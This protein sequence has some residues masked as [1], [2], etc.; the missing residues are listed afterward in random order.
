MLAATPEATDVPAMMQTSHAPAEV[1]GAVRPGGLRARLLGIYRRLPV[2][3]RAPA[4]RLYWRL[5]LR[6]ARVPRLAPTAATAWPVVEAGE[7]AGAGVAVRVF[8]YFSGQ[9]GLG[10]SARL[11]THALR[12][13]SV[14]V[15]VHDLDLGLP[16]ATHPF[17]LQG[18]LE[19]ATRVIDLVVV[20]PDYLARALPL[21]PAGAERGVARIACWFWELE[22]VPAS[23]HWALAH[24]EGLLVA[25]RFV[26]D[27]VR[28]VASI[29]VA[30]VPLPVV[31]R[32]ASTLTR[33]EFGVPADA[34]LFLSSFDFHSS[35]RRKNP[36]AV[37][38]AFRLA[39]PSGKEPVALLIKSS[40]GDQYPERLL[41]LLELAACD[42]R[43]IIRDGVI[44]PAHVR[45]LQ[46]WSD[47]F[48]SLHR[49][50]GF[51]LGLAE[52]MAL[53]KPVIA[54]GWSGNLEFM[55]EATAWLVGHW[56]VDVAP[57][58]Y[59]DA[60]GARWAEPDVEHAAR[61]MREVA[62]DRAATARTAAAGAARVARQL[63]AGHIGR[64]LHRELV[65]IAA[66]AAAQ[67][68]REP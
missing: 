23:W 24:F 37:I 31:A 11:Y 12:V 9:F 16:H 22:R 52:C 32:P 58:E 6:R 25:S 13:A 28:H 57:G 30:V 50:E 61:L 3:L 46:Q 64:M 33:G 53:G 45:A 67:P 21:L 17:P 8:G 59:A 1:D 10:E 34:F 15:E 18:A 19:G 14:P 4:S 29:P 26:A 51:G 35:I 40:N 49:A 36:D 43:I 56:L 38:R 42:P 47:A 54:T 41:E 66:A 27:A 20:N 44:E 63:D 55:S 65:A 39:F 7:C 5:K 48:V 60:E 68:E 2:D 62:N